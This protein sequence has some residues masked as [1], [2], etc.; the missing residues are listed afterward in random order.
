[1]KINPRDPKI[2]NNLGNLFIKQK[3]F[4]EALKAFDKAISFENK[5]AEAYSNR[6]ETNEK[7]G[8]YKQAILDYDEALKINNNLDYVRG[9]ILH[10]KMRIN[11][12]ENF[13]AQVEILKKE[14]K[15]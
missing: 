4:H 11:E 14:I 8:N 6:A 13:D 3:K 10:A 2:F 7:L 5:F 9:K 15:K 1:M 12:W